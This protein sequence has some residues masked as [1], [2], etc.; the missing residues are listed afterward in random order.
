[1]TADTP[2]PDDSTALPGIDQVALVVTDLDAAVRHYHR[3]LGIGPWTGFR[4]EP[5]ALEAPTYRGEAVDHGM[6]LALADLGDLAVELI[7]PTR[8]PT[9][10]EDHLR[11]RGPGLHHVAHFADD[12]REFDELTTSLRDAGLAVVQ[13]GRFEGATFRYFDATDRLGLLL[14]LVYRE[15]VDDRDPAF[16]YPPPE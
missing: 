13:S 6:R 14:E 16:V 5:P 12:Q 10:Y 11:E 15:D 9:V 4:F 1:M 2:P 8:G 7:E 3:L